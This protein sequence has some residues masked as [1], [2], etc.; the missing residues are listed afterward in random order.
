MKLIFTRSR[1][2]LSVLIRWGLKEPVSHFAIVFDDKVVFH[3]NLLGTHINWFNSFKKS[4]EVVYTLD[5]N[6][7]LEAEEQVYQSIIDKN[8][9]KS[10]DFK[11]FAYFVWRVIL[12]RLL[13]KPLPEKNTW[14]KNG[15]FLCTGLAAELPPEYFPEL[16]GVQDTEMISPYQI[17]KRF[18]ELS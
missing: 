14:A 13:G 3:S 4:C 12:W 8:I 16:D 9:D 5:R 18:P 17:A 10:Y 1:A 7:S 6:L 2:P 11:A 15:Q